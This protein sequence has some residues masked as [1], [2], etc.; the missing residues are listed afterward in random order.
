MIAFVRA[1]KRMI[2]T[3]LNSIKQKPFL[4][5]DLVTIRNVRISNDLSLLKGMDVRLIH[6]SLKKK[7]VRFFFTRIITLQDILLSKNIYTLVT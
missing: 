6:S 7:Q 3:Q 4:Q 5:V 1:E 2:I